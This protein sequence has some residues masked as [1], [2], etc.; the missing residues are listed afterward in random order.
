M[1]IREQEQEKKDT[2]LEKSLKNAEELYEK[3][4]AET[5][6]DYLKRIIYFRIHGEFMER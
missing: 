5:A 6:Y 3:H 1:V 4:G 2:F